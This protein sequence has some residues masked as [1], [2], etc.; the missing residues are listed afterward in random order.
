MDGD[1][2]RQGGISP[3]LDLR[4]LYGRTG[5]FLRGADSSCREELG[6]AVDEAI[7]APEDCP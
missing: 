7:G 2:G 3:L 5:I 4:E 1:Q 6:N